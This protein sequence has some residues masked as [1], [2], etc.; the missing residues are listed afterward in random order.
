MNKNE[1]EKFTKKL[2]RQLFFSNVF[3]VIVGTMVAI[4]WL[5]TFVLAVWACLHFVFKLF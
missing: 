5:S 4:A 3:H 1:I 2:E